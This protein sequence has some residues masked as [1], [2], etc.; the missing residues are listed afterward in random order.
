MGSVATIGV[1]DGVHKGHRYLLRELCRVAAEARLQTAVMVL[2]MARGGQLTTIDERVELLK[3]AGIEAVHVFRFEGVRSMTA[4]AFMQVLRREYNV[5]VLLMGYDHRFG[6]DQMTEFA[7]YE[8]CA[9]KVGLRLVRV[10]ESPDERVSSSRIRQALTDG[11][12]VQANALLGNPYSLTGTVV[13]GNRIGHTIGFPTANIE[14]DPCK[15]IPKAGVYAGTIS[16]E[17]LGISECRSLVNI[18]TNPTVGNE[19]VTIEAYLTDYT[20]GELYG[21]TLT[22]RFVQRIRDEKKFASLDELRNQISEDISFSRR[23]G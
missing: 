7:D 10:G 6:C 9:A 4:E 5:E 18:G 13:R 14:P 16:D 2:D 19:R 21:E 11:D 23:S 20:G 17:R 12:I 15:L 8:A 3:L 22:L 1:F